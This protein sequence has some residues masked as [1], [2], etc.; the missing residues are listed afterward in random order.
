ME[1]ASKD[2]RRVILAP[3]SLAT[4]CDLGLLSLFSQHFP[5][6]QIHDRCLIA[7]AY[8]WSRKREGDMHVLVA[9]SIWR[10]SLHTVI[11]RRV[12]RDAGLDDSDA[13]GVQV[14]LSGT[15]SESIDKKP[16]KDITSKYNNF[17]N[18]ANWEFI[19]IQL[20]VGIE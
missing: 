15:N 19:L 7:L 10:S 20:F 4:T 9:H 18:Y 2:G 12:G 17:L 5:C 13:A 6:S 8:Y 14:G 1:V 16:M 11:S 3:H